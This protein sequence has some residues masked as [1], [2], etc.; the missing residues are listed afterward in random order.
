MGL[1]SKKKPVE[2]PACSYT[3]SLLEKAQRFKIKFAQFA[4]CINKLI[5]ASQ[6]GSVGRDK[7]ADAV[8]KLDMIPELSRIGLLSVSMTNCNAVWRGSEL[9]YKNKNFSMSIP[10]GADLLY[11]HEM[12]LKFK[13]SVEFFT[14]KISTIN[15]V[16]NS[17]ISNYNP[18]HKMILWYAELDTDTI[19]KE[20]PYVLNHTL[21]E[22]SLANWE[23]LFGGWEKKGLYKFFMEETVTLHTF[24]DSLSYK[25]DLTGS[26]NTINVV[27]NLGA[28]DVMRVLCNYA[29]YYLEGKDTKDVIVN[30]LHETTGQSLNKY[31]LRY[32]FHISDKKVNIRPVYEIAAV[33]HNKK[34][35]GF[36]VSD[37]RY[38]INN[39]EIQYR[40]CYYIEYAAFEQLVQDN[41][42]QFFIWDNSNH[43]VRMYGTPDERDMVNKSLVYSSN[44][45]RKHSKDYASFDEYLAEDCAIEKEYFDLMMKNRA[46]VGVLERI[47]DTT[48]DFNYVLRVFGNLSNLLPDASYNSKEETGC[49]MQ[50]NGYYY[51]SK[52]IY[53]VGTGG[54]AVNLLIS[55]LTA[56][57]KDIS[58]IYPECMF[59]K[60]QAYAKITAQ[61][62]SVNKK[63]LDRIYMSEREI[64][65]GVV[66][67]SNSSNQRLYH[68]MMLDATYHRFIY[69]KSNYLSELNLV[70]GKKLEEMKYWQGLDCN[71][72][73]DWVEEEI[74]HLD[75]VLMQVWDSSSYDLLVIEG[76]KE[77]VPGNL[78]IIEDLNTGKIKVNLKKEPL[79]EKGLSDSADSSLDT[80]TANAKNKK[81]VLLDRILN[82]ATDKSL[83]E[84]KGEDAKKPTVEFKETEPAHVK[85]K[86][87]GAVKIEFKEPSQEGEAAD[88][89][90]IEDDTL[91][92]SQRPSDVNYNSEVPDY[93][94]IC[95]WFKLNGK[96]EDVNFGIEDIKELLETNSVLVDYTWFKKK[97]KDSRAYM[98]DFSLF[99][100]N[101][102]KYM[103]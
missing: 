55:H 3:D 42:V 101:N 85:I 99:E 41:Q 44:T 10:S 25:L 2:I 4:Y 38:L 51:L 33:K 86:D 95:K 81:S 67:L 56:D 39:V 83:I 26:G 76:V 61:I 24:Y 92:V 46:I 87:A 103:G 84:F 6:A 77:I 62:D 14:F 32:M 34:T 1:F 11:P 79:K 94:Y 16:F 47:Y 31:H 12:V 69:L 60:K 53:N 98:G 100:A 37:D 48:H 58:V 18:E 90:N 49:F 27:S 15:S 52:S 28:D 29:S 23:P 35:V 91:E 96:Y 75:S 40:K 66:A 8:F 74:L 7:L 43:K 22:Y 19:E 73:E 64:V 93:F 70:S 72:E 57:S 88:S 68:A 13:L 89:I 71:W 78:V 50:D 63:V 45:L 30:F 9:V 21:L 65:Y 54:S 5:E 80:E 97:C 59:M 102:E 36:I 82:S 17:F 20:S